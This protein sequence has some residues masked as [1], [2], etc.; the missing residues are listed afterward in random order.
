MSGLSHFGCID[1]L[2]AQAASLVRDGGHVTLSVPDRA[3]LSWATTSHDSANAMRGYALGQLIGRAALT[4]G[5][6]LTI[7]RLKETARTLP[8]HH[9]L[10]RFPADLGRSDQ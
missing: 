4:V 8:I 7:A 2:G 3:A 5:R 9:E 6:N 1:K 10:I